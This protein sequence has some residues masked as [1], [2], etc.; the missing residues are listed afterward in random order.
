MRDCSTS[1]MKTLCH[2]VSKLLQ[3]TITVLQS[4]I[5]TKRNNCYDTKMIRKNKNYWLYWITVYTDNEIILTW[6]NR[7]H[8]WNQGCSWG[9]CR[10]SCSNKRCS[11]CRSR[12]HNRWNVC[13]IIITASIL[14]TLQ[15]N[16]E[17]TNYIVTFYAVRISD[18][19]RER[20]IN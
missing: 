9:S 17:N 14:I 11:C 12:Q 2:D 19:K 18:I 10:S 20:H 7:I 15:S 8:F 16:P 6:K 4:T 3:R 5:L 1:V 13:T